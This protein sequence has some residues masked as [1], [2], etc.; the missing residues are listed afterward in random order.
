MYCVNISNKIKIWVAVYFATET[1]HCKSKIVSSVSYLLRSMFHNCFLYSVIWNFI[2]K[3][4]L[5]KPPIFCWY[6]VWHNKPFNLLQEEKMDRYILGGRSI[7][8]NKLSTAYCQHLQASHLIPNIPYQFPKNRFQW[9]VRSGS[10]QISVNS[11]QRAV[12]NNLNLV[13]CLLP[14]INCP[15]FTAYCS[16]PSANF[17]NVVVSHKVIRAWLYCYIV[18]WFWI[19]HILH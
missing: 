10:W 19:N 13:I 1:R 2:R 8:I 9:T 11:L 6:L 12:F 17:K 4:K 14:T 16:L 15:L 5:S 3:E 7:K 18:L